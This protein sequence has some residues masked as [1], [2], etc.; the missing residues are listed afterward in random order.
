MKKNS[1]YSFAALSF[2]L[3]SC[4]FLSGCGA[5]QEQ[6]STASDNQSSVQRVIEH[7][8]GKTTIKGEPKKI[9][10]LDYRLADS[11]YALGIKPYAMTSYQGETNLEY[12]EG[13][14]F[15]GVKNLGDDPNLEAILEAEPDLIIGREVH[16][17]IYDDASKIAPTIILKDQDDWRLA[18]RELASMLGKEKEADTWLASYDQKAEEARKKLAKKVGKDETV[19]Y[20]RVMAKE[21]RIHGPKQLFGATIARDLGLKPLPQV[22]AIKK[23]EVISMEKLPE[24]N[25]DHIF[26]QVGNPAKG[27]DKESDKKFQELTNSALWQQLKAVKNNQVYAVPHWIISDFPHIKEKSIEL[28]LE[29]MKAE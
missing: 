21:Y 16:A 25:P 9:S 14:P 3:A 5:S 2:I 8:S 19:L 6:M 29:K 15:E 26:I 27:P 28:V 23:F 7:Y 20:M 24:L 10:V 13:N 22:E 1:T 12:M 17:K 11:L 18:F 4:L